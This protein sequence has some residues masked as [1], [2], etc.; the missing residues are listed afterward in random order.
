VV[1]AEAEEVLCHAACQWAG[2]P[3]DGAE[4]RKRTKE[5]STMIRAAGSAGPR[6][7]GAQLV[8]SRTEQWARALIDAV[9]DGKVAPDVASALNVIARH[10]DADG[11][12]L[13]RKDAAI[14]LINL[15]RPT[16]AVARY[17]T[18][19]V[20]AMHAHPHSLARIAA[21]DDAFLGMFVQE[22][23]RYYPF[24]PAVG[25][26][27]LHDFEWRGMRVAKGTWVLLDLYGTD[28]DAAIWGDPGV[29]RPERFER[30]ESSG[31][32][33]IPQGGGD[34]HAGHRCAGEFA[35]VELMTSALRLFAG[36]IAYRVPPQDLSVSLRRM[37]TL[38]ASG[39]V[40]AGVRS[41]RTPG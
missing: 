23:R 1:H 34:H 11:R 38:P 28:H 5:F 24:F 2:I 32:D 35:T 8:R 16:V 31:F 27:A 36:E 17:I 37:P 22:V 26:R 10:R 7:W 19:G 15:L 13:D 20:L 39:M 41:L 29:F 6:N 3:V 40:L 12:L 33:L 14:E 18:F 4:A 25:G 21:G 30:R 9:R